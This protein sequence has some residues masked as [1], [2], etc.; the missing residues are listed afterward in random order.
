MTNRV[1]AVVS[2]YKRPENVSPI[3]RQLSK[4][5]CDIIVADNSGDIMEQYH[6]EWDWWVMD[7]W[8]WARNSGPPARWYPAIAFSHLYEYVLLMD[9]DHMPRVD[10]VESL[11][12]QA[13]ACANAFAVIG[14]IGRNFQQVDGHW[15]YVRRNVRHGIV[16]M[17]GAG[18]FF[19]AKH[20]PAVI[21]FRDE[22]AASGARPEMLWHDDMILNCSIQRK[23]G[24]P[25]MMPEGGWSE[26]RMN[27]RGYSF[28]STSA[29]RDVRD[30]LIELCYQC[31]WRSEREV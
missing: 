6:D 10:L 9:D 24:F 8:V 17:A 16:D 23:T 19:L 18:Y 15:R 14:R 22:L 29:Y 30:D 28:N 31:G 26:K 13:R 4:Q 27:T 3:L 25:S 2:N 20:L 1:L 11:V 5:P 12:K 21:E 7:T